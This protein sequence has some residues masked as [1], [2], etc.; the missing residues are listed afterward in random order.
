MNPSNPETTQQS[1]TQPHTPVEP[2]KRQSSRAAA[3]AA[4]HYKKTSVCVEAPERGSHCFPETTTYVLTT[5]LSLY[6]YT[7]LLR[8]W[9]PNVGMNMAKCGK[10]I[11]RPC[12]NVKKRR[13]KA[14][15]KEQPLPP[16]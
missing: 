10:R 16:P 3:A 11:G 15:K 9:E 13:S 7:L 2:H 6:L 8:K 12:N 4:A 5:L 14:S 1:A